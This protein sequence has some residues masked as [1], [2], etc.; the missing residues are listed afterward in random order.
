MRSRAALAGHPLHPVAVTIPVGAFTVTL[1]GDL[2]VLAHRA[3]PWDATARYALA[4]GI[5]G[6]LAAAVL[7][8]IDYFGVKMSAA[9]KKVVNWH[10]RTNLA[11][12]VLFGLSLW[13]RQTNPMR[14]SYSAVAASTAGYVVL[15]IGG[16][17]GGELVFKHK[18]GVLETADTE[19]TEIGRRD[20]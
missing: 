3:G 12:V 8:F 19:A 13:L 14:W 2:L 9:G 7:G 1:L 16:W 20:G 11:A 15:L 17:L 10:L 4:I 5:A 18:V 6:A